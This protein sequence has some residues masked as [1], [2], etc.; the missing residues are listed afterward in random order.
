MASEDL[1]APLGLGKRRFVRLPFGLIGTGLLSVVVTTGIV[2][3]MVVDDPLGGEP[4]AVVPLENSIE[5]LSQRDIEVVEIRPSLDGEELGPNLRP[6][7]ASNR[8]GPRYELQ[9]PAG[10]SE[11]TRVDLVNPDPRVI[12]RSGQGY[13]PTVSNEGLRPLDVYARP[14]ATEFHSI[15][16]IA[17]IVGGMGLSQ[18]G[19]E[20]ALAS[21]PSDVT[22]ALAPYGANL[23]R[24]MQQ[25][26][27][28]GHELLLQM[29]MEP[30]D[31]PDN[32]PGPHTL[33]IS[34]QEREMVDRF[35]WLL[36]RVTNYV[37]IINQMGARF[38]STRPSM[39]FLFEKLTNRGLMF[40]DDGT[41]SRSVAG[42][43]AAETKT[44]FSG[45]DVVLDGVPREDEINAKLLQLEGVARARGVAV[46]SSSALPVTIRQLEIWSR[47]LEERGL[48][49]VPV[50]ATI[51]R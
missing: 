24:W 49:L 3:M 25:A 8:L 27:E 43:V 46:A 42:E 6:D 7:E 1:T 47:D 18:T 48:Q 36:T 41:S 39:Q 51:D 16:K 31:F 44:P 37:G 32:D 17:I 26:R 19:T 5:G 45:V 21:L 10:Q 28:K 40:V 34:L 30:F 23:D 11:I 2:W 15:P 22:L 20:N 35:Q 50:S 29:P 12:E 13:L 38:M 4:I 33:L 9:K 14:V